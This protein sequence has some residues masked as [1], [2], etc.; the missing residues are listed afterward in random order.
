[1]P[2]W[3]LENRTALITGAASGI[4]RALAVGLAARGCNLALADRNVAGLE[5]TER[6]IATNRVRISRHPLD[7]ADRD[8]I[9]ALPAAVEAAHGGLDVLINNAG[10]ALGGTFEDVTE[11]DFEWLFEINF[12]GVVRM[13]RA[14]LP[15]LR[16]QPEARIVNLSSLYG[17]IAPPGQT[18][19]SA[20]KFA[21]R[22]FSQ[23]L[24]HELAGT[25]IGVTV[26]HPGGVATS[27]A[28]SA[29]LPAHM[30]AEEAA[31]GRAAANRMLKLAPERAAE[32]I[33]AA[34]ERRQGRVLVGSDAKLIALIERLVPVSYWNVI[35]KLLPR[36][37]AAT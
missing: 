22:G 27:V 31:R 26:V 34:V 24:R 17:L 35:Q 23:A 9:A 16:A 37:R 14:F 5:E 33:L 18:A 32:I 19:Y 1:M 11:A 28:D 7:V 4:G 13:T 10:V 3:N 15:L 20:S 25:A 21:V 8:A 36:D 2:N 30:T 12:W 29:R 6:L